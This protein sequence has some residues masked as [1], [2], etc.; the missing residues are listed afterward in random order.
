[1]MRDIAAAEAELKS[2][3]PVGVVGFC[4]GGTAA[5]LAACRL[6]G[7]SAAVCYYGGAIAKFADEKAR[8]PLQMHFGEKDDHIPLTDVEMIRKKQPQAQIHVYTGAQHGFHCDERSSYN[9]PSA[10]IAWGRTQEFL[11]NNMKKK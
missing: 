11:K 7:F 8:C 9:K 10:D 1:M 5:F 4:M 2:A 3:G 6:D